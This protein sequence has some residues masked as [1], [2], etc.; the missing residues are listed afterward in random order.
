MNSG[1]TI[2]QW[3][4]RQLTITGLQGCGR[5]FGMLTQVPILV[6]EQAPGDDGSDTGRQSNTRNSFCGG[7]Q[8]VL[9]TNSQDHAAATF[10]F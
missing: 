9:I 4:L 1:A 6:T 3:I 7:Q 5:K 10:Y 8:T 2:R